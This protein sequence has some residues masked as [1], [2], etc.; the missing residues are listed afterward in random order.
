MR[1][2]RELPSIN[3][4]E[5]IIKVLKIGAHPPIIRSVRMSAIE[6]GSRPTAF[7]R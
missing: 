7:G 1:R 3:L 4:V 5:Q 6:V 2:Y